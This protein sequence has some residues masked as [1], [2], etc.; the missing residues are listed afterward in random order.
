[1]RTWWSGV[2]C[3]VLAVLAT[4]CGGADFPTAGVEGTLKYNGEPVKGGQLTF[5]P[6]PTGTPAEG[7]KTPKGGVAIVQE[8]GRFSVSTYGTDDGAVVGKHTVSYSPPAPPPSD[9]GSHDEQTPKSPY[10][11]LVLKTPE[12]TVEDSG[13]T[14]EL[15][16]VPPAKATPGR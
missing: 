9:T 2:C 10:A 13:N 4:G 14:F 8:D 16:L 11:G 5:V 7:E 1:M 6:V 15:E 12:V 3:G